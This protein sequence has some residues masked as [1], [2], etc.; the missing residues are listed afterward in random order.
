[1]KPYSYLDMNISGKDR[2]DYL[3]SKYKQHQKMYMTSDSVCKNSTDL[4]QRKFY[5]PM[6]DSFKAYDT[7]LSKKELENLIATYTNPS[8]KYVLA[9]DSLI[10]DIPLQTHSDKFYEKIHYDVYGGIPNIKEFPSIRIENLY[11]NTGKDVAIVAYTIVSSPTQADLN[12]Y[13]LKRMN[14]IWWKPI[15]GFRI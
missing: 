10:R 11:F 13:F 7:L 5:C 6:A 12:F 2:I 15:G 8:E 14:G 1:M 4:T 9:I 3:K